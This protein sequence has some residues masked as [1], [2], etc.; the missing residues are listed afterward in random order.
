MNATAPMCRVALFTFSAPGLLDCRRCAITRKRM[1][2]TMFRSG[3]ES[4]IT[5]AVIPRLGAFDGLNNLHN[6][7]PAVFGIQGAL[8][9]TQGQRGFFQ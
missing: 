6:S 5:D 3:V 8:V 9:V 1:R 4:A 2:N 7:S